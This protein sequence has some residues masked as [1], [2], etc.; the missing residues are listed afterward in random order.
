M[1]GLPA[2][3]R[4]ENLVD[5]GLH[6]LLGT[7][8]ANRI[9]DQWH[10][11]VPLRTLFEQPTVAQLAAIIEAG[12]VPE[13]ALPAAGLDLHAETARHDPEAAA[14][15][16]RP[17]AA[18]ERIVV[19]G[20]TG[21]LGAQ[22]LGELL[23]LTRASVTCLVRAG[24]P[25]AA[26]QRVRDA[27]V[28]AGQWDEVFAGRIEA[29]PANL[30]QPRLGLEERQYQRL[31][32]EAGAVYHLGAVVNT[33]PPY[34]RLRGTNVGGMAEILRLA[35]AGGLRV[36]CV[37]PAELTEHPDPSRAGREAAL[38]G[39]PP[40]LHNGYAQSKWVAERLAAL[41]QQRGAA[42]TVYRAARLTGSPQTPRWKL[43]DVVTE[44]TRAC[45]R[46]GTLPDGAVRLPVSPVD[47]V[48]AAIARLSGQDAAAGGYFHLTAARPFGFDDLAAAMRTLGYQVRQVDL[49]T[50]YAELVRLAQR[51]RTSGWDLVLSVVGPWV[52]AVGG[53]WSEPRYETTAARLALGEELPEPEL[54]PAAL[55][56][57]LTQLGQAGFIPAPDRAAV[58][59]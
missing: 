43:G 41:A 48:A 8:A 59:S 55:A 15:P 1:L 45:V 24:E 29:V 54:D 35:A 58:A 57:C 37:S 22:L 17:A 47:Y 19:T 26:A 42:V 30:A 51:D 13:P 39:Q 9:R 32:D 38:S 25:D 10:T 7:R 4:R 31:A 16:S 12:G 36:H 11:P 18:P 56:R 3:A 44:L 2:V 40:G 46:L 6:S 52:R 23:R 28:A 5:L 53:G 34:R 14:P 50:W 27:L 20:A 21:Y 49:P 33:L